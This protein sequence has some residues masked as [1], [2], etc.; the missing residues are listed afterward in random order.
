MIWKLKVNRFISLLA[1]S[2]SNNDLSAFY[3]FFTPG[4]TIIKHLIW[5]RLVLNT[6]KGYAD[7][8]NL[9]TLFCTLYN[10]KVWL[11]LIIIL[12]D[13][14]ETWIYGSTLPKKSQIKLYIMLNL[15]AILYFIT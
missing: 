8:I 13:W 9:Y 7:T 12:E 11:A 14:V 10:K 15:L 5:Y 2:L 3:L 1:K 4:L 6:K